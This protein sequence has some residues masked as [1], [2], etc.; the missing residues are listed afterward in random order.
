M[1]HE[2]WS[3]WYCFEMR[4]YHIHIS[5]CTMEN[6]T[7]YLGFSTPWFLPLEEDTIK[8]QKTSANE[9]HLSSRCGWGIVIR[10]WWKTERLNLDPCRHHLHPPNTTRHTH[11]ASPERCLKIK[12]S[13]PVSRMYRAWRSERRKAMKNGWE[14]KSTSPPPWRLANPPQRSHS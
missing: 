9:H 10:A 4:L 13:R 7:K 5:I 3:P 8:T 12:V 6:T 14:K 2:D 1:L 11:A